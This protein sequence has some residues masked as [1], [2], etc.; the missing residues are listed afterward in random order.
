MP[1]TLSFH[2]LARHAVSCTLALPCG[3]RCTLTAAPLSR[4][5]F[6]SSRTVATTPPPVP[7]RAPRRDRR[8]GA[9]TDV[10]GPTVEQ[11][12]TQGEHLA[13]ESFASS[14]ATSSKRDRI[15]SAHPN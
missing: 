15:E 9:P 3:S 7:F 8:Q 10:A 2:L 5:A 4:L 11:R 12:C 6:A 14:C 1:M 13:H